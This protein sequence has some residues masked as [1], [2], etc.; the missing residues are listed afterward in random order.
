MNERLKWLLIVLSLE[1]ISVMGDYFIKKASLQAGW[2][3]WRQLLVGGFIYGATAI[4]WFYVMRTFKL[5]T[6]GLIHSLLAIA[7][8]MLL[9]Q[10]FFE[11]KMTSRDIVG[12]LLGL[13]SIILLIRYQG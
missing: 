13:A 3:G 5:F 1:L 6:I 8:S 12:I 7:L 10:L 11:E 9:S 2:S 4:G